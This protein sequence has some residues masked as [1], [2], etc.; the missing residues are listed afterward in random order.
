MA[1]PD[2]DSPR[3]R[4]EVET[5]IAAAPAHV[6][7]LVSDVTNMGRWSPETHTCKWVKGATGPAV[8]ARFRGSNKAR[9]RRWSTTSTVAIADEGKCFAFDVAFGPVSIA[10]WTYEFHPDGDGTRVVEIWDDRRPRSFV[11][12]SAVVM[13]VPDRA[14]H[15]RAGMEATLA[16]LKAAVEQGA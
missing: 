12:P 13:N 8:G 14:G 16:A 4:V 3:E 1:G 5:H 6:Y 2:T 7:A 9:W 11:K 10:R 15:N